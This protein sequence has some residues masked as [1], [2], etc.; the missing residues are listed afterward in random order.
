MGTPVQFM[1]PPIEFFFLA[2]H[3]SADGQVVAQHIPCGF[4]IQALEIDHARV[5]KPR[6]AKRIKRIFQL[7]FIAVVTQVAKARRFINYKQQS[8]INGGHQDG[9]S[10]KGL[11]QPQDR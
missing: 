1:D 4:G 5:F 6:Y 8:M 2:M 9:G 10:G 7:D 3:L 11:P